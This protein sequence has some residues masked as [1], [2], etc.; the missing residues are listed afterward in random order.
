[1]RITYVSSF[2]LFMLSCETMAV[3]I[4]TIILENARIIR[5]IPPG[6]FY[7]KDDK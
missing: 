7:L 4:E 5:L 6:G 2:F 1:M 3:R